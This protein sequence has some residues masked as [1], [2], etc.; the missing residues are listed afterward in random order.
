MGHKILVKLDWP[1]DKE[2]VLVSDR[3]YP[4]YNIIVF[5]T[6]YGSVEWEKI[7]CINATKEDQNNFFTLCK[8]S[9]QES[10]LKPYRKRWLTLH[11]NLCTCCHLCH[12]VF[13]FTHICPSISSL[14]VL[15]VHSFAQ[16]MSILG[17]CDGWSRLTAG[18][19][20]ELKT[21]TLIDSFVL[22]RFSDCWRHWKPLKTKHHK[23]GSEN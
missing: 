22:R 6:G 23:T 21:I 18:L 2:A 20:S 9:F 5:G 12:F 3:L 8:L 17:P 14:A 11:C 16:L 15:N 19:T 1:E 4:Q 10:A 13:S 7:Q